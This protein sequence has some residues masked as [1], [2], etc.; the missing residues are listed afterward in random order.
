MGSHAYDSANDTFDDI[1]GIPRL[2][3]NR[4]ESN[5]TSI[6]VTGTTNNTGSTITKGKFFY[7]NGVLAQAKVDIAADATLTLNTN[8]E[9]PTAGGLNKLNDEII[10]LKSDLTSYKILYSD[11][12]PRAL[13]DGGS[14]TVPIN[15]LSNYK[16]LQFVHWFNGVITIPLITTSFVAGFDYDANSTIYHDQLLIQIDKA[17]EKITYTALHGFYLASTN[18]I[19]RYNNA[20]IPKTVIGIEKGQWIAE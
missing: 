12:T 11:S 13:S 15:G 1:A 17:Q 18:T 16:Y 5:L 2:R 4:M 6:Y 14:T 9:L 19:G 3:L 20:Y 10:L 8:Y 7:F